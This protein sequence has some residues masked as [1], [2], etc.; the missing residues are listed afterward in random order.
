LSR[1][2]LLRTVSVVGV[3][4]VQAG[5]GDGVELLPGPRRGLR[6]VDDLQDLGTAEAADLHGMSTV[7]L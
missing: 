1:D 4:E 3:G 6:D 5:G 7:T 2:R